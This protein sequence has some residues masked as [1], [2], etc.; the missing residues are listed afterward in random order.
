MYGAT[1]QRERERIFDAFHNDP[2]MLGLVAHPGTMSHG[3][4][5]V[6]ADTVI[7]GAPYPA[8]ETYIQ[9]NARVTRPGQTRKT[10][11]VQIVG[12]P[13]EARI[14]TRLDGNAKLQGALLDM[15]ANGQGD[16]DIGDAYDGY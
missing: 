2:D 6:E 10:M 5:L 12:S 4:T 3:L 1:S 16:L 9:A 14:Y 8:L 7:W 11:I 13:V 15:F